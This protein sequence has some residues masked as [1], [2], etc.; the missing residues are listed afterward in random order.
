[1][2]LLWSEA[3]FELWNGIVVWQ[4]YSGTYKEIR[5]T[6]VTNAEIIVLK[7]AGDQKKNVVSNK[8]W[9]SLLWWSGT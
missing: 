3:S 1:M 8:V 6:L 9:D 2:M 7:E 5:L 4:T